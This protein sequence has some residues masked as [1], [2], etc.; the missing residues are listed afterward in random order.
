MNFRVVRGSTRFEMVAYEARM[1]SAGVESIL[2]GTIYA[3]KEISHIL[4]A[5]ADIYEFLSKLEY[6]VS[7]EASI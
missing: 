1:S 2:K 6:K 4:S 3:M 7:T 5:N